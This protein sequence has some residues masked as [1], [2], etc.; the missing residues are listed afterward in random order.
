MSTHS[1]RQ[2]PRSADHFTTERPMQN[3]DSSIVF[4]LKV[5]LKPYGRAT[6]PSSPTGTTSMHTPEGTCNSQS[7][8]GTPV[9]TCRSASI[10]RF[11]T[12]L[13]SIHNSELLE[14]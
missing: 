4:P 3:V 13:F 10:H 7:F 1:G 9:I 14:V 12:K 2:T 8:T 6:Q 11:P 5:S